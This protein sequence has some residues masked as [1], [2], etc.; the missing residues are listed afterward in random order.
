MNR[1]QL[2]FVAA[3]LVPVAAFANV[4]VDIIRAVRKVHTAMA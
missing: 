4:Y 3:V 1:F 2:I